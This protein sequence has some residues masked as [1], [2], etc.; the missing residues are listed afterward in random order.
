MSSSSLAPAPHVPKLCPGSWQS[1]L[2]S[3]LDI[4]GSAQLMAC[5]ICGDLFG[6]KVISVA[7]IFR[8]AQTIPRLYACKVLCSSAQI[9]ELLLLT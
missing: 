8:A 6:S 9:H 1:W 5:T 7:E 2:L 3:I 4:R